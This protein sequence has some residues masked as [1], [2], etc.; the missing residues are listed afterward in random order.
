MLVTR[1]SILTD[2]VNTMDIPLLEEAQYRAWTQQ[3]KATRPYV[4]DEFPQLTDWEREFLLNG[5][6]KAEHIAVFG[7]EVDD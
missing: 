1:R 4:Q 2:N 7:P 3:P 5:T 6:T